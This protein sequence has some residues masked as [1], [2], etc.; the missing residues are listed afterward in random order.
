[1]YY[2][3]FADELMPKKRTGRPPKGEAGRKGAHLSIRIAAALRDKL[4]AARREADGVRSLSREIEI[5][6]N[7]SFELDR[8]IEKRFGGP[9]T[10]RILEIV[11]ERIRTIEDAAGGAEAETPMGPSALRWFTDRF[12][13]DQV[14]V[15]INTIFEHFRPPGRRIVPK[16]LRWHP[17]LKRDV[18]NL[19]RHVALLALAA[20]ES[21]A[22]FSPESDVPLQYD[23]AALPLGRHLRGSPSEELERERKQSL[24]RRFRK[25]VERQRLAAAGLDIEK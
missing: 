20:L 2:N 16:A 24:R 22:T 8:N 17:S 11:G 4:E 21:A 1:V 3:K 25:K 9:G 18:E 12:T 5:R 19:G 15:M 13:H 14:M 7:E 23:K 6:L 10:A